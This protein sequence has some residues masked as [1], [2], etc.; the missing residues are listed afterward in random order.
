VWYG[1]AGVYMEGAT[2]VN[3]KSLIASFFIVPLLAVAACSDSEEEGNG[4]PA[5]ENPLEQ[6]GM[7]EQP[8]LEGIP[9]VV[10]VVNGNE[11]LREDFVTAYEAQFEQFAMQA[12]MTGEE[13]DEDQLKE[14]TAES[15]VDNELLVQEA[16]SRGFEATDEDMD[17][18]LEELAQQQGLESADDFMD[19]LAEQG[20]EEGEVR[21]QL[22]VQVKLEQLVEDEAGDVEPTEEELRELYEQIEAQQEQMGEGEELPPFDEIR[23]ELEEQAAAENEGEAIQALIGDLREGADVDLNL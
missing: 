12:Q 17:E 11:I 16:D 15:L 23:P 8:D 13:I 22:E 10:A 18:T 1:G 3:K 4:D 21:S 9:D 5:E 2:P 19:A 14:Q 7:P 20:M 6:E